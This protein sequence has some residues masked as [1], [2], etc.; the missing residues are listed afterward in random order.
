MESYSEFSKQFVCKPGLDGSTQFIKLYYNV[1]L[2]VLGV[3]PVVVFTGL[4]LDIM[5]C[6]FLL[7]RVPCLGRSGL[8][9]NDSGTCFLH[10]LLTQNV[11]RD[12]ESILL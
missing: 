6:S 9:E 2:L 11:H 8:P 3:E 4:P 7:E 1:F 5:I 10:V 12:I